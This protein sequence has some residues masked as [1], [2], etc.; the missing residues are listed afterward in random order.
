MKNT[1]HAFLFGVCNES[2]REEDI[3]GTKKFYTVFVPE[4][5]TAVKFIYKMDKFLQFN[6]FLVS[7]G[8]G[9]KGKCASEQKSWWWWEEDG[10]VSRKV[11]GNKTEEERTEGGKLCNF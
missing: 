7:W 6:N 4:L 11:A 5:T 10:D 3:M 9:Q 8:P 2:S 1:S